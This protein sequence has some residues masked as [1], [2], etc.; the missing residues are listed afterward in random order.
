MQPSKSWFCVFNNPEK[1]GYDGTPEEIVDKM[2]QAWIAIIH[3]YMNYILLHF[4]RRIDK[5]CEMIDNNPLEHN[6]LLHTS[7]FIAL[8]DNIKLPSEF[9]K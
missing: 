5:L 8:P 4:I 1:H 6:I 7:K 9:N 3:I 2:I